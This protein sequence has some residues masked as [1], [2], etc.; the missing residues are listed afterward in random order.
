MRLAL[1]AALVAA[2]RALY[3]WGIAEAQLAD[4]G[5]MLGIGVMAALLVTYALMLALPFVPGVEIGLALMMVEGAWMA[6]VVYAATIAGLMLAFAAGRMIPPA[7]LGQAARRFG[8]RRA[9]AAI[10]RLAPLGREARLGL[11]AA[12][13]PRWLPAWVLRYRYVMLAVLVNLPGNMILGG[14]GGILLLAGLSGL[15]APAATLLAL[16]VAVLPVPLAVG[17]L[18]WSL[19]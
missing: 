5:A 3:L 10:D 6:P 7:A 19:G 4:H 12:G 1:A 2:L 11:I 8:L 13:L 18:G 9:A 16:I 15:Y 17:L 14:G